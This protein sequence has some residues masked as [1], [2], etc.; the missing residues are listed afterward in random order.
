MLKLMTTLSLALLLTGCAIKPAVDK[1]R[2]YALPSERVGDQSEPDKPMAVVGLMPVKLPEYLNRPQI[3][4]SKGSG[5]LEIQEYHRW[6]EPL[7]AGIERLLEARLV[8]LGL[9]VR[10]APFRDEADQLLQ[11]DMV[12]FEAS[13]AGQV[14]IIASVKLMNAEGELIRQ[15]RYESS[16]PWNRPDFN[17]MTTVMVA[18]L[19]EFARKISLFVLQ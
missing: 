4:V 5:E 8:S 1:S 14:S 7:E 11:V 17:Q 10:S 13:R 19:D 15:M 16:E 18:L 6:A 3:V 9:D 2:F 12:S